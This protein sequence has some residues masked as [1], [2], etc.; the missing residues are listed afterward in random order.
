VYDKD[1]CLEQIAA[2]GYAWHYKKYQGEQTPANR[3]RYA[4]AEIEAREAVRGLWNDPAPIPPREWRHGQ[5]STTHQLTQ[6]TIDSAPFTCGAKRFCRQM[7]SWNEAKFHLHTCGLARLDGDSDGMPCESLCRRRVCLPPPERFRDAIQSLTDT[8]PLRPGLFVNCST[9]K[10]RR[11]ANNRH[12]VSE[13]PCHRTQLLR[14]VVG[15]RP[16][17]A[18]SFISQAF[19]C[20]HEK[21][22]SMRVEGGW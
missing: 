4:Q 17:G 5:R 12:G 11:P 1:V 6:V 18:G 10:S 8:A 16:S 2:A 15:R 20:R 14:L 13:D 19:S 21:R 22:R 3:K 7:V 9:E